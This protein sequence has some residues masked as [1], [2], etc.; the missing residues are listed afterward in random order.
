MAQT[1]EL[2]TVA[3]GIETEKQL[4]EVNMLG[5]DIAQ[6]YYFSKPVARQDVLDTIKLIETRCDEDRNAA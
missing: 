6:G 1:F 3:E 4:A 2:E 5:I